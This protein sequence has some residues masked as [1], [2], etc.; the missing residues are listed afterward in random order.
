M[1]LLKVK[2]ETRDVAGRRRSRQGE[3]GRKEKS[4]KMI[5]RQA[6]ACAQPTP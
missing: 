2:R 6:T 5:V 3:E 1:Q 4:V